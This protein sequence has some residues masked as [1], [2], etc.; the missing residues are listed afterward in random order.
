MEIPNDS[1]KAST[2]LNSLMVQKKSTIK[3]LRKLR[4]DEIKIPND[5][6]K[7]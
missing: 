3:V 1:N 2:N 5:S 7:A 4:V 6:N